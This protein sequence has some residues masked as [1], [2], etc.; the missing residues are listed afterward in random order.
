MVKRFVSA[1]ARQKAVESISIRSLQ[2]PTAVLAAA[3]AGEGGNESEID[4]RLL[5]YGDIIKVAP[6][7]RIPTN[8]TVMSGSSAVDESMIMGE[9]WPSEKAPGTTVAASSLNGLGVLFFLDYTPAQ[10]QHDRRYC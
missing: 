4:S 6:D 8:G 10:E 1:L 9:L 2:A 3:A 5:Q 7:S